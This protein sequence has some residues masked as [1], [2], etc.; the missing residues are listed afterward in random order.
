M[1]RRP[2]PLFALALALAPLLAAAAPP[3][4]TLL[5][6]WRW[7]ETPLSPAARAGVR[8]GA[9]VIGTAGS[10]SPHGAVVTSST[11]P[12]VSPV[13]RLSVLNGQPARFRL[14][15]REP[16][17]WVESV[18]E[19]SPR[20]RIYASPRQAERR[21]VQSIELTPTWLGGRAPVRVAFRVAQDGSGIE[22]TAQIAMDRWQTVAQHSP[23]AGPAER[24]TIRSD[25]AAG[26][27][28]R[29]LQLRVSV[30]P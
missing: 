22:S 12:A 8:D 7:V 18:V 24:G 2:L 14:E 5:V 20:P 17:Q 30:Q 10:V 13:Q 21:T 6:E 3:A 11:P 27:P 4:V 19:L 26:T 29:E 16:L 25:D 15:T 23:A 1:R 28:Q 9:T